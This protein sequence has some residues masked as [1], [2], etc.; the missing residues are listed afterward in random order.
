MLIIVETGGRAYALCINWLITT[1]R[2]L[3]TLRPNAQG[4]TPRFELLLQGICKNAYSKVLLL[5]FIAGPVQQIK[6]HHF[7]HGALHG[8]A[9]TI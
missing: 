2:H 4:D 1:V 7:F 6:A 3:L 8:L 9:R 5:N